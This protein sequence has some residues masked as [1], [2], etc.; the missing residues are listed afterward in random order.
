MKTPI[1]QMLSTRTLRIACLTAAPF[2]VFS[3]GCHTDNSTTAQASQ[4]TP[5]YNPAPAPT[6]VYNTTPTATA[7]PR[8][9]YPRTSGIIDPNG[10]VGTTYASGTD[11]PAGQAPGLPASVV[12]N[13]KQHSAFSFDS[14]SASMRQDDVA[15]VAS[16]ASYMQANPSARLGIDGGSASSPDNMRVMSMTRTNSVRQALIRA[17]VADSRMETGAFSNSAS[18]RDHRVEVLL[19]VGN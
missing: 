10:P 2:L 14:H 16:I 7:T 8:A 4:P 17:G 19:R 12:S 9:S 6:P 15:Q 3:M 5:R 13:W 1:I 11:N 18:A